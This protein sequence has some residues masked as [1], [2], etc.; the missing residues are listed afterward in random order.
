MRTG[1]FFPVTQRYRVIHTSSCSARMA[2]SCTRSAPTNLRTATPTT[3][4][5][6]RVSWRP[7]APLTPP[8]KPEA[9][10]TCNRSQA[11]DDLHAPLRRAE[12]VAKRALPLIRAYDVTMQHTKLVVVQSHGSRAEADLAKGA[13]EDAG[14]QAM[15]QAD[16][17]G[18]MREHLAWSGARKRQPRR[19]MCS[20]H[21]LKATRAPT[22]TSK[23]TAPLDH[24]GAVLPRKSSLLLHQS[25]RGVAAPRYVPKTAYRSSV[26]I[27]KLPRPALS[28]ADRC[29]SSA[30]EW[31]RAPD[32]LRLPHRPSQSRY[33][34]GGARDPRR[35]TSRQAAR[36][37]TYRTP[38]CYRFGLH[39]GTAAGPVVAGFLDPCGSDLR[40]GKDHGPRSS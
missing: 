9:V 36:P 7:T 28:H 15:I 1:H 10:L 37:Q 27:P 18:G 24:R 25:R 2:N 4:R 19:A 6:L 11:L 40:P 39:A 3:S 33:P 21:Q 22:R 38:R 34:H 20:F 26:P 32:A 17:A 12:M 16:T 30:H 23:L 29:E 14:I 31:R 5:A 8:S 13:L 35:R